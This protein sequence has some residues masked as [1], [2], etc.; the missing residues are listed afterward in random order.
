MAYRSDSVELRASRLR[1]GSYFPL[2]GT[3]RAAEK[4]LVAVLREAE[5]QSV[6]TR[7]V[8]ALVQAMEGSG[9]SKGRVPRLCTEIDGCA[10]TFLEGG[11]WPVNG[12][13]KPW[14]DSPH[15]ATLRPV[16]GAALKTLGQ[17]IREK[18]RALGWTQERLADEARLDR[19]YV[20]GIERGGRNITFTKLCQV[21]AALGCDV[22][23]MTGGLPEKHG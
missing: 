17:R 15:R 8:G 12:D 5:V 10:G 1:H 22:A 18:R 13:H 11:R 20:G 6:S 19:S 14:T 9:V 3:H 23:S 16:Y 7:S 4:A 21:C 2:L